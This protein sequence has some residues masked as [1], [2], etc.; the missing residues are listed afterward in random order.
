LQRPLQKEFVPSAAR[1]E[2]SNTVNQEG[3]VFA[4]R[5]THQRPPYRT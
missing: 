3:I 2:R 5:R 1:V 4:I